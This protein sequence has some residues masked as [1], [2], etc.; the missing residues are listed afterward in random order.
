MSG[1]CPHGVDM[2]RVAATITRSTYRHGDLRRALLEAG[3][4]LA[5]TGGPE[6]RGTARSHAPR[7]GVVP[8]AAYRHFA[9]RQDLLQAVRAAA[10]SGLAMA[11][12]TE[13]AAPANHLRHRAR[14][15]EPARG[16][17]TATCA[18]RWPRTRPVPRHSRC[19]R[20]TWRMTRTPPR[21]AT[22]ASTLSS[23]WAPRSTIG[24][25]G[26]AASSAPPRRAAGLEPIDRRQLEGLSRCCRYG[27]SGHPP[28]SEHQPCRDR[29]DPR[30][31]VAEPAPP[32]RLPD[33]I[34]GQHA[35]RRLQLQAHSIQRHSAPAYHASRR[36]TRS[37]RR[38]AAGRRGRYVLPRGVAATSARIRGGHPPR[39]CFVCRRQ[40]RAPAP[41]VMWTTSATVSSKWGEQ[42]PRT[43]H[44]RLG[45]SA[46]ATRTPDAVITIIC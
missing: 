25:T 17:C 2:S 4:D 21:P 15:R 6:G 26:P 13:L 40:R 32:V 38:G 16:G 10:L 42:Q 3:I 7:A 43:H 23:C 37:I 20:T 22:A 45:E 18:T 12:E 34:A 5:R 44:G 27:G 9:S 36:P 14:A 30:F 39:F 8:N 46:S 41:G 19:C 35:P 33:V 24:S 1:R 31:S 29:R 28:S 11:M